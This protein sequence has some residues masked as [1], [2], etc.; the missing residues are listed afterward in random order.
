MRS[1]F[2]ILLVIGIIIRV[3]SIFL[4]RNLWIEMGNCPAI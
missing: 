1:L 2:T 4:F 3:D